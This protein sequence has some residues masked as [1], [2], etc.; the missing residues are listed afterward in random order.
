[1]TAKSIDKEAVIAL[2]E[3]YGQLDG[4]IAYRYATHFADVYKTLSS[5]QKK[6]LISLR[7]LDG[8]TCQGAFL[9]S[10]NIDMPEVKDTDFLF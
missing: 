10:K 3:K 5:E 4:E 9:Y 8:F 7:N 2:S 6:Q 1:M